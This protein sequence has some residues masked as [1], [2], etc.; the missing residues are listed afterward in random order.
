MTVAQRFAQVFGAVYVLVGIAG[1][2]PPLLLGSLPAGVAGPF[3]GL[4]LG[5]FAVNWFHS[6]AHL[7]I[8]AAGLASYR[9]RAAARSYALALGVAYA[10]L[11]VLGLI[12]GLNFLGGLMPLNGADHVLHILTALVA[13][14]AYL[15]SRGQ[16]GEEGAVRARRT[17]SAR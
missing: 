3:A 13:F 15:A 4:L 10:G 2:L 9:S 17:P 11:F 6:L 12:F 5:L 1:F 16:E 14:G 7:L 8:G